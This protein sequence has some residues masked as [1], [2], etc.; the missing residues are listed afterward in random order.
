[1][2]I[3]SEYLLLEKLLEKNRRLFK[4]DIIQSEEYIENHDL[5]MNKLKNAIFRIE[6]SDFKILQELE[7]DESLDRYRNE[8]FIIRYSIN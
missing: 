5:I 7:I 8:I 6:I 3:N 1:M 4:K 2:K